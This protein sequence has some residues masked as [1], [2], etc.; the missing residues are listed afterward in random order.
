MPLT[1]SA[2]GPAG[3]GRLD[4]PVPTLA[5]AQCDPHPASELVAGQAAELD[6]AHGPADTSAAA[7]PACRT[8]KPTTARCLSGRTITLSE[9]QVRRQ[10]L[11]TEIQRLDLELQQLTQTQQQAT[12]WQQIIDHADRFRQLLGENL[13]RLSF[14]ERQLVA[15]CLIKKVVVTGEQV[16]I[17]YVLP[18]D[19]APQ[20]YNSSSQHPEGTPGHFYRL[21]LADLHVPPSVV[22]CGEVVESTGGSAR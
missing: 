9:L 2:G 16:D 11:T 17:Y 10:K 8:P 7:S 5:D 3:R 19:S 18:F 1:F 12:H 14:A 13:E 22:V 21:R 6:R 4:V 20:V 15:Q